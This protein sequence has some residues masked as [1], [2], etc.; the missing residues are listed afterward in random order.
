M[1]VGV[2]EDKI[3]VGVDVNWCDIVSVGVTDMTTGFGLQEFRHNVPTNIIK[4]IDL[5]I[6]V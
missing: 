3:S 1:I 5:I 6:L 4:L 2:G